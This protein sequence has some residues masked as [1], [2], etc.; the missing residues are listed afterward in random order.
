MRLRIEEEFEGEAIERGAAILDALA[1]ALHLPV[2]DPC[3]CNDPL[4]KAVSATEAPADARFQ[5]RAVQEVKD[6]LQEAYRKRVARMMADID[7]ELDRMAEG[8]S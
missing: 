3:G 4:H 8:K 2:Q 6:G 7:R 1:R 5:C